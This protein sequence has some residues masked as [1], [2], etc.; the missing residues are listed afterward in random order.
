M[1]HVRDVHERKHKCNACDKSFGQTYLLEKHKKIVHLGL[2]PFICDMC[3]EAYPTNS[4]LRSHQRKAHNKEKPFQCSKCSK[5]FTTTSLL[6]LKY[7]FL[8]ERFYSRL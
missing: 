5:T 2:R 7:V 8:V 4:E 1:G 6:G 3:H